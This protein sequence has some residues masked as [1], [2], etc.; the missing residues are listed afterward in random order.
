MVALAGRPQR[1]ES[2]DP[3]VPTLWVESETATATAI[4][5]ATA[6]GSLTYCCYRDV[7]PAQGA[8]REVGDTVKT[9]SS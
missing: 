5:R 8:D 2:L 9:H 7:R 4:L 6:T 1:T 3:S